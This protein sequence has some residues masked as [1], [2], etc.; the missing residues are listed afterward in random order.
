MTGSRMLSSDSHSL[1]ECVS[2]GIDSLDYILHGGIH[3][4]DGRYPAIIVKGVPGSGKTI[5]CATM[6]SSVFRQGKSVAYF[7]LEQAASSIEMT[8]RHFDWAPPK[9]AYLVNDN[10]AS[11]PSWSR[12]KGPLFLIS[13]F[14]AH[15]LAALT[16]E[17]DGLP[18]KNAGT[19]GKRR[20]VARPTDYAPPL[21]E[22]N[23]SKAPHRFSPD[24][25]IQN[26][27]SQR[28]GSLLA[29]R[30]Q[31]CGMIIVDSCPD[32]TGGQSEGQL[33]DQSVPRSLFQRM[34]EFGTRLGAVVVMVMETSL[35][36]NWQDYV[37]DMVIELG[38]EQQGQGNIRR[39]LQVEKARY[40][41][42]MDGRHEL[43]IVPNTGLVIRPAPREVLRRVAG[44][45]EARPPQEVAI[46]SCV[47]CEFGGL[48]D[49]QV[50]EGSSTLLYGP[51]ATRKNAIMAR[52]LRCA[53]LPG[54]GKLLLLVTSVTEQVA[55]QMIERYMDKTVVKGRACSDPMKRLVVRTL[56]GYYDTPSESVD[57]VRQ[58]LAEEE[59]SRAAVVD[60]ATVRP[61][62]FSVLPLKDLLSLSG[63]TSLFVHS[64]SGFEQSPIR[65]FFDSVIRTAHLS[66]PETH[67]PCVGYNVQKLNGAGRSAQDWRELWYIDA[68]RR[69]TSKDSFKH[70]IVGEEGRLEYLRPHVVLF[71][72]YD[73]FKTLWEEETRAVFGRGGRWSLSANVPEIYSF[74]TPDTDFIFQSVVGIPAGPEPSRPRVLNIDE[75]WMR[76]LADGGRLESLDD[77]LDER[78]RAQ[79]HPLA[80][81]RASLSGGTGKDLYGV[82]HHLDFGVYAARTDLITPEILSSNHLS[83]TEPWTWEQ[84]KTIGRAAQA[85][86][87][88]NQAADL[89]SRFS[90]DQAKAIAAFKKA[91]QLFD[92]WTKVDES[93]ISFVL[94]VLWPFL[95]HADRFNGFAG[96]VVENAVVQ[97]HR[98]L[99]EM[100]SLPLMAEAMPNE[101]E[102]AILHR[103][104]I[105]SYWKMLRDH[106]ELDGKLTVV[107]P[108]KLPA[109]PGGQAFQAASISGEW[110]LAILRGSVD[111]EMGMRAIEV[112]TS[113]SMGRRIYR[114]RA[115]IPPQ[116]ILLKE[117]R[118]LE[119]LMATYKGS[120]SR[121]S[122]PNYQAIRP[123]LLDALR[124]I[125]GSTGL[126]DNEVRQILQQM[127]VQIN[128]RTSRRDSVDAAATLG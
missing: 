78:S 124:S 94:E 58:V 1:G 125:F 26:H 122:I 59:I 127:C 84:W 45:R 85:V 4:E 11:V 17:G 90:G 87:R 14:P 27:I 101:L 123:M 109:E 48:L 97:L 53:A 108:P 30:D 106:P 42:I 86:H 3:I 46:P 7:T 105:V 110:L 31:R 61:D 118:E 83:L 120:V 24:V 43:R 119:P 52:F 77:L 72:E 75:Q 32:I 65:E 128:A 36:L 99:E 63:V 54:G 51:D 74:S 102:P 40:H 29:N 104:W 60:V 73:E 12:R 91:P 47:E 82:P 67:I 16:T 66:M 18:W 93:L 21:A 35:K 55:R 100:G 115:G 62:P 8:I 68:Q 121:Q 50:M 25:A 33:W 34:C 81:R 69:L 79:F 98:A 57:I 126:A 41:A 103:H 28:I 112:L 49:E 116:N 70:C 56:G 13:R 89:V 44:E 38:W 114:R 23:A 37:A 96:Q 10:Y 6:A 95:F 9:R 88:D 107:P 92:V 80:L 20:H 2:T 64:T 76:A 117:Y 39:Y 22:E 15:I 71:S 19:V 5:L 113:E 111:R